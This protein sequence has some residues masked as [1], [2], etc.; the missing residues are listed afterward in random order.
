VGVHTF[1]RQE[2][3]KKGWEENNN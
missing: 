2:P 3:P 1:I